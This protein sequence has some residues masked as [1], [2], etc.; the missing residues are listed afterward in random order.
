MFK[1]WKALTEKPDGMFCIKQWQHNKLTT[2]RIIEQNTESGNTRYIIVSTSG[3]ALP[4][5]AT[6]QDAV[7]KFDSIMAKYL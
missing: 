4:N 7:N 6:F 5:A 2:W 3:S 1:D